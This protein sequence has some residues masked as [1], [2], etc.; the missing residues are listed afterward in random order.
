MRNVRWKYVLIW[1]LLILSALSLAN[2]SYR[3]I[4][5][6]KPLEH[7]LA[8]DPDVIWSEVASSQDKTVVKVSLMYVDDLSLAYSRI[9]E[10][11]HDILGNRPYELVLKDVS[12]EALEETY[13]S[14]HYYIEEARIRGNFGEMAHQSTSVLEEAGIDGFRLTVNGGKIYVQLRL[15]DNYLYRIV[16]LKEEKGGAE[17]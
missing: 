10:I 16:D 15:E 2:Y 6:K 17:L 9:E 12:N 4:G 3:I 1:A 7:R 8:Q 5:L 13:G 14:I 11:V